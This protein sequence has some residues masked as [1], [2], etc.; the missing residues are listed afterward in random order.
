MKR[1]LFL[2]CCIPDELE[3]EITKYCK[4]PHNIHDAANTFQKSL[5]HGFIENNT[6][7]CLIH[8]VRLD[9]KSAQ[10]LIDFVAGDTNFKDYSGIK[11]E[12]TQK[13]NLKTLHILDY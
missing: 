2:S 4:F 12:E 1:I 13:S 11:F 3:N 9:D 5:I 6:V 7:K 10:Y 8:E